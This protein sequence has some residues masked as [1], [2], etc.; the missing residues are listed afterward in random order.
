VDAPISFLSDFGYA[1][2]FVGVVHGVIARIAPTTRVIDITH[3]IAQGDIH[4]GAMAL[5]RA[6]QYMPD[7]VV[8]AVVDP[9]VGTD[10]RA[11]AARTPLGYFVGPDNGVLAPA[12][13]MVGGA[14]LIVSLE[15]G[16][17]Q[18]PAEGGTF[19]GRDVFGPAAAVLASGQAE[20]EDLGPAL[21]PG[22]I[23][24]LLIPL[25]EPA[26]NGA[27]RGSVLWVDT[28]GNIQFNVAPEDLD[29][30]GMSL[31]DDVLVSFNMEDS[32]VT[33]GSTYGDVDE[34][35]AVIHVDSH[36]QIAI[37]VRGGRADDAFPFGV[38]DT[39]VL[40]RPDGG[41]RIPLEIAE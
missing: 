35:E 4:G 22:S 29:A 24:P 2:E 3:G 18:L 27:V 9:G 28:F 10:R 31:G 33:W 20:I 8:L 11:I 13:A 1:D 36:G 23:S 5:T 40:G 30:L 19:D 21:D 37:A 12:V 7:G 15:E 25:A 38:G 32:R 26:G 17:Y 41:N 34:G 6:V 14:D 16:L 39:V